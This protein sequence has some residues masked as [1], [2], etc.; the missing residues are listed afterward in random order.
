MGFTVYRSG[1]TENVD[2]ALEAVMVSY[3]LHFQE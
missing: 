2:S 1:E 3:I